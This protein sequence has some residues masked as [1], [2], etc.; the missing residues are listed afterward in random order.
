MKKHLLLALLTLSILC[1]SIRAEVLGETRVFDKVSSAN[2]LWVDGNHLYCGADGIVK[3]YDISTTPVTP[4]FVSSVEIKGLARQ[5]TVKYNK[6][7]VT[8]RETGCWIFDVTDPAKP[9]FI[10]RYDTIEL[11]TGIEV[12]GDCM[13]V[14]QR[15]NG[16]EFVDIS[17]PGH[18]EHIDIIKTPESQSVFYKDGYLY[19]GEWHR[20][21][22]TVFDVRDL[23]KIRKVRSVKMQGYGDGLWA[24]GNRLYASTGHHHVNHAEKRVSGDGHGVEIFDISDPSFPKFISRVE[25]D[26]FYKV[27]TD[28]W[29]PRPSGDGKTLFC[30]DVFNGGY[31]IDI[32]NEKNPRI[33]E[34]FQSPNKEVVTSVALGNGVVYFSGKD[35]FMAIECALAS[36]ST[37]QDG[38]LPVN[39][40]FRKEYAPLNHKD[41]L[42]WKPDGR[43]QTHSVEAFGDA[44]F[45]ACGDAGLYVVKKNDKGEPY[46][47]AHPICSFVGDAKVH[48]GRLYLAQ[49]EKGVGVYKIKEGLELENETMIKQL[50]YHKSSQVCFWL[51]IPNDKYLVAGSRHHGYQ[52]MAIEG[53]DEKPVYKYRH[54]CSIDVNYNKYV[55][56]HVCAGDIFPYVARWGMVWLDLSSTEKVVQ[57]EKDPDFKSSYLYGVTNFKDGMALR[58]HD[59]KLSLMVPGQFEDVE[60]TYEDD[61]FIG[62][63]RWDGKDRILFA[64]FVDRTVSV[65]NVAD[66]KN[67]VVEKFVGVS[68]QPEAG[69]FWDG[70]AVA[71]C[72]YQGIIIEK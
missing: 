26:T 56:T 43:G 11:A 69:T 29:T 37:R 70:K 9:V 50:G 68:G 12:A 41:F 10:Q 53:T 30:S 60:T 24:T 16:V 1:P 46:T 52:F 59:K 49:A 42:N 5:M 36:P 72:G 62:Q 61:A 3:I 22:I 44:L 34:R 8:A 63:P 31:V 4:V 35:G 28:W 48:K 38:V 64:N 47:F 55:P 17:K 6:L 20:G 39:S 40:S 33:L 71:P 67:P 15:Q 58:N 7:F 2:C 65:V 25:F 54:H 51:F 45:V 14:G 32:S 66:F 23:S 18:A 21:E 19:S 57:S 27:A 13:F